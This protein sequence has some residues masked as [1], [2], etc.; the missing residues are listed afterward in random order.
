MSEQAKDIADLSRREFGKEP[1][2]IFNEGSVS[3][4]TKLWV[5]GIFT[6]EGRIE[7]GKLMEVI[8]TGDILIL[9]DIDR[10]ARRA[11][12]QR[13]LVEWITEDIG[14]RI[15]TYTSGEVK[16]EDAEASFVSG[17]RS[18]VAEFSAQKAEES[19][20]RVLETKIA[21]GQTCTRPP[22]GYSIEPRTKELKPVEAEVEVVMSIFTTF[23]KTASLSKAAKAGKAKAA[24]LNIEVGDL[25][26]SRVRHIL[27][28][29]TY[30]GKIRYRGQVMAGKHPAIVP[31]ELFEA[32]QL[33]SQR[34]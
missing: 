4:R 29:P 31:Q 18:E 10:L 14:A 9:Y 13:M 25:S 24:E 12:Y 21:G 7:L 8:R 32:V 5:R 22:L 28:N 1:D 23:S 3:G 19:S 16:E 11:H 17:I 30:T 27:A 6:P 2:Q 20:S 34:Q 26:A 15:F 33:A